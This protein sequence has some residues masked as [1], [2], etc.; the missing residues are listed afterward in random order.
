MAEYEIRVQVFRVRGSRFDRV[1]AK[2]ARC[3]TPTKCHSSGAPISPGDEVGTALL[4]M[5]FAI[6]EAIDALESPR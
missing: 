4:D 5:R 3:E 1:Y 2:T 6:G